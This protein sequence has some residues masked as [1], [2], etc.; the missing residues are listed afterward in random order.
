MRMPF[1]A[2]MPTRVNHYELMFLLVHMH[3]N[4]KIINIIIIITFKLAV[5]LYSTLIKYS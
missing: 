2:F 3:I 5:L 1:L 4:E